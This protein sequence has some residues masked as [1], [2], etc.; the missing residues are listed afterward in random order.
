ML[1]DVN[2]S[3]IKVER[4]KGTGY[5]KGFLKKFRTILARS[6]ILGYII[7]VIPGAGTTIASLVSYNEAKRFSKNKD[8]F[9]K[10]NPEGI[11]ASETANNAAVSGA[12]APLLGLG[13]PG[14]ASAAIII[15]ALTIQGVQ[16]G[17]MLFT[18]NPEIPYSIFVTLI[19]SIPLML[20]VGLGGVQL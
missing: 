3:K 7:G 15:G 19:V 6:S 11:V 10:G 1:E 12:F 2:D 18:N 9:G 17:P 20:A 14:S 5:P 8:S 16:P 4:V 13:I